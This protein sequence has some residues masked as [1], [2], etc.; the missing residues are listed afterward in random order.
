[1][2]DTD[3]LMCPDNN[4]CWFGAVEPTACPP[5]TG[6]NR[7]ANDWNNAE[8][9][10]DCVEVPDHEGMCNYGTLK[11]DDGTCVTCPQGYHCPMLDMTEPIACPDLEGCV[12]YAGTGPLSTECNEQ[13]M[14][15][16]S[17]AMDMDADMT[18]M[19]ATE[20]PVE[21]APVE[22]APVEEASTEEAPADEASELSLI[23]I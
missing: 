5:G 4:Y 15:T 12:C 6:Y 1:M 10:S 19:P 20:A 3:P 16:E 18:E 13:M 22:E 23:H 21:E 8:F 17:P 7:E 9:E 11:A 2:G 14:D